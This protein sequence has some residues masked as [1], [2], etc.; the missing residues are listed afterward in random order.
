MIE[1]KQTLYAEPEEVFSVAMLVVQEREFGLGNQIFL[2]AKHPA[3]QLY[4]TL[5]RETPRMTYFG[6]LLNEL[7]QRDFETLVQQE[8]REKQTLEFK[9]DSYATNDEGTR[10]MLRDISAMANAYGGDILL[11]VETIGDGVASGVVG[12]PDGEHEA[13]RITSSC[14]SNIEERIG[15]LAVWPV[16]LSNAKHVIVIRIP[17]S[18][19]APHMITFKGL[20]QFWVRHDRQ[21][22]PM[23]V[24]EIRETCL[25]VEMLTTRVTEFLERR[26]AGVPAFANGQP[27]LTM[28]LTPLLIA[29]ETIITK[30]KQL[31]E[32]IRDCSLNDGYMPTPC[33][34]GLE[35][36]RLEGM[37][38]RLDRNGHLDLWVDLSGDIERVDTPDGPF[39]PLGSAAVRTYVVD[40]C[41]LGKQVYEHC[42]IREPL[43]AKLDL[44]NIKGVSVRGKRTSRLGEPHTWHS[45]HLNLDPIELESMLDPG[46]VS[47]MI[48][49]RL[50]EA[51]GF[52][53][54]PF[55]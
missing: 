17:Q 51:F 27:T 7:G 33:I 52:D 54:S 24:H 22:S 34:T 31:R 44:W 2:K 14:L 41:G 50:G 13:Q 20:N 9:R 8:V 39:C 11:G 55:L 29:R 32:V 23:S 18:L 53:E 1:R 35:V 28:S 40:L 38:L 26:L 19:R 42:G 10:E 30:N 36:N 21:K 37:R 12:V 45:E 16:A 6:K 3:S 43:V 49:E 15:G 4:P 47:R 48:L 46:A 5:P 25:K